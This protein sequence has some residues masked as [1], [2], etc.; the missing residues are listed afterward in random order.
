MK[1]VL[2]VLVSLIVNKAQSQE[3]FVIQ[4]GDQTY[5]VATDT[6]YEVV[7]DGKKLKFS[8]KQKDTLTFKDNLF[9]FAYLK[10]YQYSKTQIDKSSD[11]YAL[12]S[13]SGTGFLVQKHTAINPTLIP[14]I[15]L[16]EVV[17]ENLE[18]GYTQKREDYQR[19]LKSGQTIKVLKSVLSYKDSYYIYE[20][21]AMGGKDE[22]IVIMTI[23][24]NIEQAKHDRKLVS[25]LWNSLRY[26]K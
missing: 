20:V 19:I 3:D 6:T 15:M 26:L 25:L 21:A 1:F 16:Q 17:K 13:A 7:I 24:S 8:I 9:S 14:E 18:Y 10:G 22:G 5:D 12:I 2:I 4:L 11:Q 23:D